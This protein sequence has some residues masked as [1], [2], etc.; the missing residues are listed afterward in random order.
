MSKAEKTKRIL[1]VEDDESI[2][3]P[4]IKLMRLRGFSLDWANSGRVALEKLRNEPSFDLALVDIMMPEMDGWTLVS[5]I[6]SAH[7]INPLPIIFLSADNQSK[8]R[9]SELGFPFIS[10]PI[11]LEELTTRLKEIGNRL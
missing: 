11:D 3:S 5:E 2:A 7:D 9:A 4:L 6:D 8:K 10:K 1:L